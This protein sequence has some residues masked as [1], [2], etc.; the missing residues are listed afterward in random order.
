MPLSYR[1]MTTPLTTRTDLDHLRCP[2][3]AA[4]T[5]NAHPEPNPGIAMYPRCHGDSL[6][7]PLYIGGE[8]RLECAECGEVWLSVPVAG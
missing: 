3:C 7:I 2:D 5:T 6:S 8:L 1:V 4:M